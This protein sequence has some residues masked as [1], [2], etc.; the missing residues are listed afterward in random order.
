MNTSTGE[1]KSLNRKDLQEIKRISKLKAKTLKLLSDSNII[2]RISNKEFDENLIDENYL[3][4]M[5]ALCN[6]CNA[7]RF[8]FE[9]NQKKNFFT[10]L[11]QWKSGF[12]R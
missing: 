8:E 5:K 11:S 6:H 10:L 2:A 9:R 12:T 4:G 1:K 7:K 3:G